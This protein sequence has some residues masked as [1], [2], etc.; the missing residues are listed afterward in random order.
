MK[1]WWI[2]AAAATACAC[3]PEVRTAGPSQPQTPPI[4][5]ADPRA[6]AYEGNYQQV[7]QGGLYFGWYGC[8]QCHGAAALGV[9][10][11]ADAQWRHGGAIDQIYRSIAERHPGPLGRYRARIPVEQLWQLTAYVRQLGALAPEQRRRQD[12]DQSGQPQ[13]A[14]WS[15]PIE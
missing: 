3:S 5:A 9:L 14:Q 2:A 13:A 12:L 7:S 1:S 15:G 10:D 6:T 8:S 4:N 11:L